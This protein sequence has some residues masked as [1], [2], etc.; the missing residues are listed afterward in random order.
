MVPQS[1]STC[2]NFGVLGNAQTKRVQSGFQ[3]GW[4]SAPISSACDRKL[5]RSGLTN[6]DN[7]NTTPSCPHKRVSHWLNPDTPNNTLN[8]KKLTNPILY[9]SITKSLEKFVA[10]KLDTE[11]FLA[12]SLEGVLPLPPLPRPFTSLGFSPSLL[13]SASLSPFPPDL[14]S[15]SL[16]LIHEGRFLFPPLLPPLPRLFFVSDISNTTKISQ[17]IPIKNYTEDDNRNTQAQSQT[18]SYTQYTRN[19]CK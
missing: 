1:A 13:S 12:L 15:F 4:Y 2:R 9:Q 18:P 7:T 10:G 11:S 6:P 19:L 16:E 17:T 5:L 14:L 8:H 3:S